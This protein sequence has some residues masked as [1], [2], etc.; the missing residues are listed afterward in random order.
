M[1]KVVTIG[2][3]NGIGIKLLINL[4]KKKK[5]KTGNYILITN[6][7]IFRKFLKKNLIT[8]PHIII[9]D[10]SNI[11]NIFNNYL[12]VLNIEAKNNEENC[13]NSIIK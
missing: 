13:Y 6:V 3:I 1:F 9:D 10:F 11:H 8:I 2:D 5:N 4:W 7:N 12:P